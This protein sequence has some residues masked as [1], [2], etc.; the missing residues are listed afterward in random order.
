MKSKRWWIVCAAALA[1]CCGMFIVFGR[2]VDSGLGRDKDNEFLTGSGI[3]LEDLNADQEENLYKLAKV[4]GFVKYYHPAVI[5]GDINWDAELFRVMPRVVEAASP[6]AVNQVLYDWLS[7][8]P[9]EEMPTTTATDETA[10]HW[11]EMEQQF[12]SITADLSWI[13]DR[14]VWGTDLCA[15]LEGLSRL[16]ISDRRNGYAAFSGESPV[17]IVSFAAEK[18]ASVKPDDD[19]VKLLAV[20]RLWNAFAYY[21]P[22]LSLT[23]GNW[24]DALRQGIH[25]ML[26][27][28]DQRAYEL[29]LGEMM[30]KTGDVHVFFTGRNVAMNYY[31][32]E[33][34][35][36]C[37]CMVLDG[38]PVVDAVPPEEES[39]RPGDVITAVDGVTMTDRIAALEKVQPVPTPGKYGIWFCYSLVSAAD[40][41]AQVTVERDGNPL[42]LTVTTREER[43]VPENPWESGLMEDGQIGYIDPGALQEG[44][45]ERLMEE[46][47]DTEGIIVDLRQYPSEQVLYLLSEY[48]IPE[49]RQFAAVDCPDPLRPGNF[50]RLPFKKSGAGFSKM[51]GLSDR[52]DYPLYEGKIVLLINEFSQS[53]SET[54]AMGL[55][56]APRA[57]VVGSP[58]IGADGDVAEM[59]LPGRIVVTFSTLGIYT[60]EGETIQRVG[61]QPDVFCRPTVEDLRQGRDALM[62]TAI[63]L[64]LASDT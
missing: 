22:Y 29:A 58:S 60:P 45:V 15:Y 7:G 10:V 16:E 47:A 42:T 59:N 25:T 54:T 44:D 51:M 50:C 53:Q 19:G 18:S 61:V 12:G 1:V 38:C 43:F 46:F 40:S 36:P 56:Q 48:F 57:V 21:S 34:Y 4:W 14:A 32:G 55:R 52:D 26:G 3:T 30:A 2:P 39:L 41:T 20:F 33:N 37:H 63:D 5:A 49:P 11:Y 6:E 35:L 13:S 23:D 64:I 24:D 8:F 17:E 62:E 9:Y 28:E 27:A 31:F